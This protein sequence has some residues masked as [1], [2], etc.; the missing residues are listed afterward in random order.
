MPTKGGIEALVLNTL[1]S[2]AVPPIHLLKNSL[3]TL[4]YQ[5]CSAAAIAAA[6]NYC[7]PMIK[8]TMNNLNSL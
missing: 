1:V 6:V 5:S 7:I 4:L 8:L 3:G 2:L